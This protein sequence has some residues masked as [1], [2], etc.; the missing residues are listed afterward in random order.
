VFQGIYSTSGRRT[1]GWKRQESFVLSRLALRRN[2]P[3]VPLRV[4]K[5]LKI[6]LFPTT[7]TTLTTSSRHS[8]TIFASSDLA[9]L[10]R[11]IETLYYTF[12]LLRWAFYSRWAL[13]H[14]ADNSVHLYPGGRDL[15]IFACGILM[16][17]AILWFLAWFG[18]NKDNQKDIVFNRLA[19]SPVYHTPQN[20]VCFPPAN[21][22]NTALQ[23]PLS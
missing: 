15:M 4:S 9:S 7:F 10:V 13:C 12:S 22:T 3:M 19:T 2:L 6:L 23:S 20:C 21:L 8:L 5:L 17:G 14:R 11:L 16:I 18:Q 1:L